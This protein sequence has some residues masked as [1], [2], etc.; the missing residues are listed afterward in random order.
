M[1]H[2]EMD[3]STRYIPGIAWGSREDRAG[4]SPHRPENQ[5]RDYT[6]ADAAQLRPLNPEPRQIVQGVAEQRDAVK[7]FYSWANSLKKGKFLRTFLWGLTSNAS[8]FSKE[9][10]RVRQVGPPG[11]VRILSREF[12]RG[13]FDFLW[14]I[15]SVWSMIAAL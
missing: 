12:R 6:P 15:P 4:Y 5:K 1:L 14:P 13:P 2:F 3:C 7:F 9:A 8:L 11:F 10:A